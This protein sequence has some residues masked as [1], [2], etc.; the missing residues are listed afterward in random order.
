MKRRVV[1]AGLS[2]CGWM[3]RETVRG[4]GRRAVG[5]RKGEMIAF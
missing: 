1:S 3:A 5:L 4:A 2:F